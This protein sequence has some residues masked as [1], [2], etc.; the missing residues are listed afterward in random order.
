MLRQ[1][2][3]ARGE[4]LSSGWESGWMSGACAEYSWLGPRTNDF[5]DIYILPKVSQKDVEKL[6]GLAMRNRIEEIIEETWH[7]KM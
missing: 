3:P 4:P 2:A 5:P 1:S 6:N 7:N